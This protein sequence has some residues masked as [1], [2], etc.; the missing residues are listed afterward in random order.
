MLVLT[1]D[2]KLPGFDGVIV[3]DPS[4]FFLRDPKLVVLGSVPG[5]PRKSWLSICSW[6][7]SF[8]VG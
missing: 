2:H 8:G 7:L 3:V 1:T 4:V 5:W 6:L